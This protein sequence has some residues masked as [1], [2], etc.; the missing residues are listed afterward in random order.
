M[1][2]FLVIA[3][4]C[5]D[6]GEREMH[7]IFEDINYGIVCAICVNPKEYLKL[8]GVLFE[9]NK[10]HKAVKTGTKGMDFDKYASRI[11]TLAG[12]QEG[13][14]RF[15][16][17][18]KTARFK[19]H[20]GNMI[21]ETIEKCEIGQLNDKRYVFPNGISSLPYGHKHLRD[22]ENFKSQTLC[23]LSAQKIIQFHEHNLIRLEHAI[24]ER[25]ERMGVIICVLLQQPV[26]YKK[27]SLKRSQFQITANTRDR[28]GFVIRR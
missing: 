17:K 8:Y 9:I 22:L 4:E 21:M 13:T 2:E 27:G 26:F 16:K 23:N 5:C 10:N 20:K 7:D 12:T 3:E 11:L 28:T 1:L 24:L 25:N 19:N 18:Q 14:N 6:L 15:A